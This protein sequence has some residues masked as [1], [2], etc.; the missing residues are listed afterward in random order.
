[1]TPLA[2]LKLILGGGLCCLLFFGGMS[3]GK[4]SSV[5]LIAEKD[6]ALEAAARS[7]TAAADV[8]DLVNRRA[9]EAKVEAQAQALRA[10]QAVQAAEVDKADYQ[11]RIGSIAEELARARRAPTCK[12]QLEQT[13]CVPLH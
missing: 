13:V 2:Y 8:L 9:A 12:A 5:K 11:A 4:A 1:M 6:R 10:E 3:C 7:L